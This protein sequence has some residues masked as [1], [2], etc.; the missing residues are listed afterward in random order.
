MHQID[1]AIVRDGKVVLSHLPFPDG[2]RVRVLIA[3][4]DNTAVG[5]RLPIEEVRRQ[6]KGAVIGFDEP[7]D[8]MIPPEEWEM[9]K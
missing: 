1:G 6:L 7:F 4:S 5:G 9:L 8:P 2:Q 3:E